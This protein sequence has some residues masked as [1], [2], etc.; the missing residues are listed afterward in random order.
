MAR[1][2]TR[3]QGRIL[4]GFVVF[5]GI[6]GSGTTTQIRLLTERCAREG[7]PVFATG[8]PTDNCIGKVI[9]RV[10]KGE[11]RLHPST[12]PF[13]FASDRNEHLYGEGGILSW[14]EK[15]HWVLCDRYIFSSLAYQTIENDYREV[16]E[17]NERFP[18]PRILFYL[19]TPPET[20]IHRIQTRETKE[21]YEELSFQRKVHEQ[22]RKVLSTY[23][24]SGMEIK[25]LDGS[26]PMEVIHEE[27]WNFIERFRY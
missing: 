3:N 25:I 24:H 20:G 7:I 9:R 16:E 26:A 4:D 14:I 23:E 10:L 15:G 27:V 11:H 22:Y 18:L 2:G 6:D 17:L 1:I 19:E 21:I 8:E 12:M 13:L 5:E